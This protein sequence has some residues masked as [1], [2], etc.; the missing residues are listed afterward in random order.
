MTDRRWTGGQYDDDIGLV[1]LSDGRSYG[2]PYDPYLGRFIQPDTI[3]PE[4]EN[5]QSLNRYTYVLN[6]PLRYIDPSG[7]CIPEEC[8]W[9]PQVSHPGDYTGPYD[10]RYDAWLV[11]VLL[12]LEREQA[13][14]SKGEVITVEQEA[15]L[16]N[17]LLRR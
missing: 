8:P 13:T 17:S 2:R 7:Y 16:A 10:E 12:W 3:V 6:N 14:T 11:Q 1:Y 5:P 4:P 9:V 15:K